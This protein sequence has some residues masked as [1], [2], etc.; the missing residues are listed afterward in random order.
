MF[1]KR[2]KLSFFILGMFFGALCGGILVYY[3]SVITN[4]NKISVN[5]IP[6]IVKQVIGVINTKGDQN[7]DTLRAHTLNQKE[8]E[9]AVINNESSNSMANDLANETTNISKDSLSNDSMQYNEN[10]E[11][12]TI[13]T[14]ELLIAKELNIQYLEPLVTNKVSKNDSLLAL[15]S[16][17]KEEYRKGA[18]QKILVELWKS[19][20]NYKGYQASKNKIICFGMSNIE[21]LKLYSFKNVLYL[22][23]IET[24][25]LI[26]F[27]D[28]FNNYEKVSDPSVI[29]LINKINP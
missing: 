23:Y 1:E 10:D 14:E 21:D 17:T 12:I 27:N 20:I 3:N 8:Q 25:Y 6:Q 24:V 29:N 2:P 7:N 18:P 4:E 9:L 28:E 19:P 26:E 22:K 13:K 16:G 15:V 11:Q 5:L